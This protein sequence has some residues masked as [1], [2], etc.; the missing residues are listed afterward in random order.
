MKEQLLE[1][2]NSRR[3]KVLNITLAMF[4]KVQEQQLKTVRLNTVESIEADNI[5]PTQ[6]HD[7]LTKYNLLFNDPRSPIYSA[8]Q[9][10][11]QY[12][13]DKGVPQF[14]RL[15]RDIEDFVNNR[16][17]LESLQREQKQLEAIT[18][19][20]QKSQAAIKSIQAYLIKE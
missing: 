16:I 17:D 14:H 4:N 2:I 20:V 5:E 10:L 7:S 19:E 12:K 6:I 11:A 13:G 9:T 8:I 15:F 18:Q 1:A 3:K